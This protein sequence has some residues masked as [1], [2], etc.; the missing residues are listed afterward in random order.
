MLEI[1]SA[2]SNDDLGFA[3][4]LFLEYSASLGIAHS[5]RAAAPLVARGQ[6]A[7][8][9][10]PPVPRV[11]IALRQGS[12]AVCS[13]N[14][15][16]KNSFPQRN[17]KAE[18]ERQLQLPRRLGA[19]SVAESIRGRRGRNLVKVLT[20]AYADEIFEIHAIENIERIQAEFH[21]RMLAHT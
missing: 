10:G 9:S 7:A 6:P 4:E 17:S 14:R 5:V 8:T 15:L 2:R 18:L 20:P 13:S 21:P 12:W 11:P 1:V 3:R 19:V 16:R